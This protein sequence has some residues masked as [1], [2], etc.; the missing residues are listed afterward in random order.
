MPANLEHVLDM[1]EL[2]RIYNN[3]QDQTL[4]VRQRV[5]QNLDLH[6]TCP[7]PD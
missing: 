6:N 2:C 5:E 3:I 4:E 1:I 7:K